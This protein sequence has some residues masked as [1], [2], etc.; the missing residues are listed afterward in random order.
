MSL[1]LSTDLEWRLPPSSV[2]SCLSWTSC[3]VEAQIPPALGS[4]EAV[5]LSSKSRSDHLRHS[6]T[7]KEVC[8]FPT[9]NRAHFARPFFSPVPSKR[10]PLMPHARWKAV[11]ALPTTTIS[12][13][14]HI[15]E[16]STAGPILCITDGQLPLTTLDRIRVNNA[17]RS[18]E[19]YLPRNLR[20][21]CRGGSTVKHAC[22]M[23]R[24]RTALQFSCDE[25]H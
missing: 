8:N 14:S 17:H 24:R 18:W 12:G 6:M 21:R 5:R 1:G 13:E 11:P 16:R 20:C 4:T 9:A 15:L 23:A 3:H 19:R 2:S 7:P 22:R 25:G 10:R